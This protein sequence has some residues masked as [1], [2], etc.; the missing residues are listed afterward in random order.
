MTFIIKRNF[1]SYTQQLKNINFDIEGNNFIFER[2]SI[3]T[4]GELVKKKFDKLHFIL[5]NYL[6]KDV[7]LLDSLIYQKPEL[8][9]EEI[10]TYNF[11]IDP[12]NIKFKGPLHLAL[13]AKNTRMTNLLLYYMSKIEAV[14]FVI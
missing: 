2:N 3:F 13:E 7:L 14:D 9:S 5:K 10:Q 4:S 1:D 6:E 8:N 12:D 11:K